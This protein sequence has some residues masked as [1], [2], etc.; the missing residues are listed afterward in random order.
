MNILRTIMPAALLASIAL[1]GCGTVN[2]VT[3]TAGDKPGAVDYTSQ[4]NDVLTD[5]FLSAKSVRFG[6]TRGGP[7]EVQVTIANNDFRQR[8][9]AYIFRWMDA[10]GMVIDSTTSTWKTASIAS[11]GTLAISSVAPNDTSRTFQLE[12]RR[13]K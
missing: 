11:G 2:T 1:G 4:I 7:Y 3:A 5:L 8:S 12:T 9:F 10:N 6:P 13:S